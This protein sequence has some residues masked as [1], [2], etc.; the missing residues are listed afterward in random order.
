MAHRFTG[1]DQVAKRLVELAR[2]REIELNAGQ[3]ASL[4]AIAKRLTRNGVLIADEVGLG[5][6]RIA[7]AVTRAVVDAGGRVAIVAPPVL[8]YQWRD[9]LVNQAQLAQVPAMLR[10]LNDYLEAWTGQPAEHQPWGTQPVVLVSHVFSN[11]S[12][13]TNTR[14]QW[15]WT[16]LPATLS[17]AYGRQR[18]GINSNGINEDP[19]IPHAARWI[20]TH[21]DRVVLDDL[22]REPKLS[23]WGD[24]SPMFSV[25]NYVGRTLYR[26]GLERIVGLGLGPFDLILIDEAHKNRRDEGKLE[27]LLGSIL[28]GS[29]D[30]RRIGLTATPI[31]LDAL[32]WEQILGRLRIDVPGMREAIARYA[33]A[34]STIQARPSEEGARHSFEDASKAFKQAFDPIL[35]RRDKREDEAVMRFQQLS[36]EGPHAYRLEMPIDI[37]TSELPGAWRTAICAAEALSFATRGQT[38]AIAKRLRLTLANGHGISAL[39]DQALLDAEHDKEQLKED[40]IKPTHPNEIVAPAGTKRER[41]ADWWRQGLA[42]AFP[43]GLDSPG[44][45]DAALCEHPGI[46]AAVTAIEAVCQPPVDEKALVFGRFTRP[47]RV[48]VRLL[49]ARAL[50]RALLAGASW[51]QEQVAEADV[52]T[53][54]IAA[55]QLGLDWSLDHVNERL[56]RQYAD[57]EQRREA[58]RETLIDRL[59]AALA[60]QRDCPVHVLGVFAAFRASVHQAQG[61]RGPGGVSPLA[62][63]ARAL[64]ELHASEELARDDLLAAGFAELVTAALDREEVP[65]EVQAIDDTTARRQWEAVAQRLRGEFSASEGAFARLMN[66]DSRPHTRRIL[67]LAFNRPHTHP[68]VLVA[69]SMVGRE[70]LNLHK[71]CR[72]VVLLHPEWNPAVVEQQ[73]GRVDRLGSLWQRQLQAWE[74]PRSDAD[75]EAKV[76]AEGGAGGDPGTSSIPRIHVRPIVFK[77]T[78]DEENWRVLRERWD[79]LRAQ[80][81]GIVL[82]APPGDV[83]LQQLAQVINDLAPRFSPGL[84]EGG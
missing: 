12:I 50:L 19:R 54:R 82:V 32:Q 27:L 61:P 75:D 18:K 78:Y 73:I 42:R 11:W 49:N 2:G 66:G 65:E 74:K 25:D 81:H 28:H 21:G 20:H 3:R 79:M 31:E 48:L 70:G 39:M 38:D 40:G 10:S 53:V 71:A 7:A 33:E 55:R 30:A 77:G 76:G 83:R 13:K 47:M 34:V 5:K 16:L 8:G 29:E 36:G 60:S 51:P 9:E 63:V 1:W 43:S 67:Q 24:N 84:L 37:D 72:T 62:L 52:E 68:K 80:L 17:L 4:T 46:H 64:H 58:F 26:V 15:K 57:L 56:R 35:L 23:T 6:T 22:A 45:A 14:D 69:Q 59:G 44:L 41:R